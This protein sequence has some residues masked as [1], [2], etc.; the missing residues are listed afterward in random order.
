M[1]IFLMSRGAGIDS[2]NKQPIKMGVFRKSGSMMKKEWRISLSYAFF[3]SAFLILFVSIL[4]NAFWFSFS[5]AFLIFRI[6]SIKYLVSLFTSS[7]HTTAEIATRL[8]APF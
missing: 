1:S 8:S 6:I 2:K 5:Y 4:L 7:L 3:D